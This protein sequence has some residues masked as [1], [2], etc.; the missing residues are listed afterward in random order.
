MNPAAGRKALSL[1]G[2][3]IGGPFELQHT[4]GKTYSDRDLAGEPYAMF[5][6]FTHCPEVCPT[7][8]WE[9]TGWMNQLGGDADEIEF[10]FRHR[11]S[12]A[13]HAA[14]CWPNT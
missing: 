1:A 8:L 6:G 9:V 14:D 13:R 5:F 10:R 2:G 7:T 12:R 4:D 3:G 11:R